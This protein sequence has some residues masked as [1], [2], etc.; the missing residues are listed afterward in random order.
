MEHIILACSEIGIIHF[1]EYLYQ[2]VTLDLQCPFGIAGKFPDDC[3]GAFI[4]CRVLQHQQVG[5]DEYQDIFRRVRR[6]PV[7]D[8]MQ[9]RTGFLYGLLQSFNF[10]LVV[11]GGDI[12]FRGFC[13]GANVYVGIAYGYAV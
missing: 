10:F 12:V 11:F 9:L 2:A 7:L 8:F 1:I 5:V 4:K 3:S 13:G 6:N